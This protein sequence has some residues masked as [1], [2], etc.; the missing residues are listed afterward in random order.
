MFSLA[1]VTAGVLKVFSTVINILHTFFTLT[2]TVTNILKYTTIP[3]SGMYITLCVYHSMCIS[4]YVYI[5]LCVY[6][7]MCI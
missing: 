2:S 4:L 6:N 3:V 1:I 7:S 5:T